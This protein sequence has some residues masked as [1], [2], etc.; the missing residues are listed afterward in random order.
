MRRIFIEI[1]AAAVLMG[2]GEADPGKKARSDAAMLEIK[3]QRLAREHVS[4]LVRDPGSA[5]FRGQSGSC[6]EVNSKN[7][8]GAYTGYQRFIAGSAQLV[9]F[10]RDS[11]VSEQDFRKMWNEFCL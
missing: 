1:G 3:L 2:C 4:G 7:A 9:V 6:G 11:G 8:F 5:E 10:E